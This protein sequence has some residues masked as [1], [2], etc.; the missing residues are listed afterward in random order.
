MI[1]FTDRQTKACEKLRD[2]LL[3]KNVRVSMDLSSEPIGGKIK[4]AEIE[5]LPYI[6]VI[7][8]KEEKAGTLAVRRRGKITS[9]KTKKFVED[10]MEEIAEKR[11][12]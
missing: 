12:S 8:D 6:I 2:E 5:K 7:G 11:F 3:E 1:N 4:Q 10:I 9:V